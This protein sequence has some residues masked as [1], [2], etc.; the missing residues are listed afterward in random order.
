M[1]SPLAP[2]GTV[3]I[4]RRFLFA[5]TV[6]LTGLMVATPALADKSDRKARRT[7]RRQ[8][9]EAIQRGEYDQP[10]RYWREGPVRYLLSQDEDKAF[11]ALDSE[12]ERERYIK[13]FW[14]ARDP[15]PSAPGNPFRD[16]F[17]RRVAEANE[18]FSASTKPGWLTD[19]GKTFIILGPPDELDQRYYGRN[20]PVVILWTYRDPPD[21]SNVSPNSVIRF[22]RDYSGEFRLS[23]DFRL[24][25][26]ETA[27]SIGLQMQAMQVKSLPQPSEL[28]DAVVNTQPA[29]DASPFRTHH[30]FFGGG[31]GETIAILTLGVQ[32]EMLFANAGE[33]ADPPAGPEG[34]TST[35]L[36]AVARLIP[37][38]G[39]GLTYD[40]AGVNAL[41][42]G[43]GDAA[44]DAAGYL[45]FQGGVP[46][47]PG[48]YE[49]YFGIFDRRTGHIHSHRDA[50]EV[51]SFRGEGITV[52][53]IALASKL[54]RLSERGAFG[55]SAPFVFGDLRAVPRAGDTFDSSM[56]PAST[57]SMAGPT[58]MSSTTS[59]RPG[60]SG[61]TVNRSTP[62]SA[63]RS[64]FP[65]CRT[66]CRA[67]PSN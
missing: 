37:E 48:R 44:R 56:E 35:R 39:E 23:S 53:N 3:P 42:A 16:L 40:L 30:E 29:G 14:A 50:F 60:E 67:T 5:T 65:T 11:R 55:Y 24:S 47:E 4:C 25:A 34:V 51:P 12:Q 19:R 6:L 54:E 45:L 46:V 43:T 64:T 27:L 31:A 10:T 13:R 18:Y 62:C 1:R 52:S 22:V 33:D 28:L 59:C 15:D 58:S 36:E 7:E 9:L 2:T 32:E 66:R 61:R 41:R 49:A 8:A 57:P 17:Y 63:I 21:G 38:G 26:N 20:T